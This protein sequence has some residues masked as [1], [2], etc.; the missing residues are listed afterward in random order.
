MSGRGRWKWIAG[1]MYSITAVA[2]I[3]ICNRLRDGG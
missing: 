1:G 3:L 2:A